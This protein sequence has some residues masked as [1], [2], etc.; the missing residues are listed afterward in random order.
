MR[1]LIL[2]DADIAAREG[3]MLSRLEVGLLSQ[4]V[5]ILYAKPSEDQLHIDAESLIAGLTYISNGSPLTLKARARQLVR[6][7]D[8]AI[9]FDDPTTSRLDVVHVFGSGAWR[10]GL[11]TADFTGAHLAVEVLSDHDLDRVRSFE[12]RAARV[13]SGNAR[14]AW[15]SPGAAISESLRSTARKAPVLDAFW[16]AHTQPTI[17]THTKDQHLPSIAILTGGRRSARVI[18]L[19]DAINR[20][21]PD[22]PD[23]VPLVFLDE[24][25]VSRNRSTS[26]HARSLGIND[27]LS[28]VPSLEHSRSLTLNCDLLVLP[29]ADGQHR[30]IVLDAMSSGVLVLSAEDPLLA[31]LLQNNRTA[32]IAKNPSPEAWHELLATALSGAPELENIRSQAREF[33]RSERIAAAQVD[34]L[35]TAYDTLC[36]EASI[37]FEPASA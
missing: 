28:L 3:T 6:S 32:L 29:D 21:K 10:M 12:N 1:A 9:G 19:L 37:P 11:Y 33:V 13:L 31:D 14:L 25:A 18:Q 36:G 34:A 2:T 8:E 15:F 20:Y 16:G 23:R 26:R 7:I 30:S 35:A 22:S 5:R 24:H 4:S 27:R 17:H